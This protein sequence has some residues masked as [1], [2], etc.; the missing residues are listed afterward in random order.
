MVLYLALFPHF[1]AWLLWVLLLLPWVT[2]HGIS[3]SSIIS[4]HPA[5]SLRSAICYVVVWNGLFDR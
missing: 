4:H 2:I 1:P 3:L 5:F